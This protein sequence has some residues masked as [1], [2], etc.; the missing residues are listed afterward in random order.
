M[1]IEWSGGGWLRCAGGVWGGAGDNSTC[2]GAGR[3]AKRWQ[4]RDGKGPGE[5]IGS[6][7]RR[8]GAERGETH[9]VFGLYRMISRGSGNRAWRRTELDLGSRKSLDDHHGA[10][11]VGTKPK[12]AG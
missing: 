6:A 7:A 8:K 4:G 11:T 5:E 9:K 3:T 12:R 1:E 2:L 10:A